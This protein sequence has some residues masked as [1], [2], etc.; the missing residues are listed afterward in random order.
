LN[1]R[2]YRSMSSLVVAVSLT[3]WMTNAAA[4]YGYFLPG[5]GPKAVGVAGT[6]VAMPLDRMA[7]A[8][9]PAGLALIDPGLD[10]NM[11]FMHPQREARL[12]CTNIGLCDREVSDRSKRDFFAVP[13]FGYSRRWGERS[14]LGV[15]VYA[16]GGL[17]TTYGRA[18]VDEVAARIAGQRPGDPG[19]PARG[20]IGVDLAQTITALNFAY[21]AN[22]QWT[23]GIAPLIVLQKF[24][25]RGLTGFAPLSS[26]P[27]SL[28]NRGADY[29]FGTGV[30]VGAI[31]Q[32]RP[33]IR[34]GAQY[35]SQLFIHDHTKYNG[36]FAQGGGFDGPA[37]FTVGLAW[38]AN[39]KLT[40]AFDYQRILFASIDSVGNSGPTAAEVAG[41]IAPSRLLGGSNGIGFGWDNVSVYKIAAV[42]RWNNSVTLR[43]AWGHNSGAVPDSQALFAPLAGAMKDVVTVGMTYQF[44]GGNELSVGYFRSFGATVRNP[45][46]AFFGV[47][48]KAWFQGDGVSVGFGRNF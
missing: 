47:P 39:P 27:S 40:L 33:D 2:F 48:V 42:Y 7:G 31:Y 25:A 5:Y 3:V 28:S 22:D 43:T 1:I 15:T 41:N 45:Q 26:D 24:S 6:G 21:R 20:K 32:L 37:H 46:T 18:R 36:L 8:I 38:Q 30:R 23:L 29:Q 16:N 14:T 4:L 13:G 9:N 35:T 12:D 10:V 34:L 17:N 11:V 44:T 19:F